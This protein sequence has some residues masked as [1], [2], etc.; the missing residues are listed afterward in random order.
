MT[1]KNPNEYEKGRTI[2][3]FVRHG[4]YNIDESVPRIP[5]PGLNSKGIKQ[6]KS[7]AKSF[8]RISDE[9]D[10]IYSSS[11]ARA[12]E[13]AKEINKVLHKHL[14][15]QEELCEFN[16][17]LWE[18]KVHHPKFWKHYSKYLKAQRCLDEILAKNQGK[19]III[20]AHGNV[21]KGILG[22]KMNIDFKIRGL[23]NQDNC[24]VTKIRF[25]GKKF[26]YLYYYN[27]K[28]VT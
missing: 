11:M 21:I 7:V 20:V 12:I 16:R 26:S 10:A 19:V 9:V 5:G 27:N 14:Q 8:K 4:D 6:A 18:R 17:F 22:K 15:V 24:H 3:Y 23:M 13:T 1:L 28:E 2:V 25:V